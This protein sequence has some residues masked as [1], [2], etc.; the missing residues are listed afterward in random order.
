MTESNS[1]PNKGY[2]RKPLWIYVVATLF[3]L[4]PFLHLMMTLRSAGETEWWSPSAWWLWVHH[5]NPAPA[6]I[7]TLLALAGLSILFVRRWAWWL[8]MLAL[9]ALCV[10]NIALISHS[11]SDDPL[12]RMVATLGSL[13]LLVLLF[14]S[15]FKQPFFNERLRWWESEARYMVSVPVKIMNTDKHALLVN[16]SKSGIYLEPYDKDTAL[17][18]PTEI[19]VEVNSELQLPCIYSR[20]TEK[21]VAYKFVKITKHQSRYL[22]RW[23]QLLSKDPDLRVR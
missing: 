22:R 16:I 2:R 14:F 6:V 15:E 3:I 8:G 18:L 21:G 4:T 9:G 20:A 13:S 10:Y 19:T 17:D 5:L 12:T 23:L 11:F 7:S 1:F